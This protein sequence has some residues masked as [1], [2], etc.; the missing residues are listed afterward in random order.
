M[1]NATLATN[2]GLLAGTIFFLDGWGPSEENKSF[3][4]S[5]RFRGLAII[6]SGSIV[7]PVLDYLMKDEKPVFFVNYV[8]GC[9]IGWFFV[10]L[11]G[12]VLYLIWKETKD[13]SKNIIVGIGEFA[14][15]ILD[16]IYLGISNNPHLDAKRKH[17][18]DMYVAQ[19]DSE[20]IR[21]KNKLKGS[22]TTPG[23]VD[24]STRR[25]LEEYQKQLKANKTENDY[26]FSDWYYKG[27]TEFEKGEYEK[28]IAYMKNAMDK[29]AKPEEYA[30]ALLYIGAAYSYL[31]LNQKS[32]EVNNEIISKYPSFDLLDR[33]YYNLG[34]ALTQLALAGVKYNDNLKK[35]L[36]VY[37]Q[38]IQLNPNASLAWSN[39]SYVLY[40][41]GNYKDALTASQKAIDSDAKNPYGW[42][43]KACGEALTD[44][45]T[46]ALADLAKA[47][48]LNPNF[49]IDAVANAAFKSFKDDD[50]FKGLVQ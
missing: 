45:K 12:L 26:D 35:A 36:E 31:G 46:N 5:R 41:L 10:F 47:I 34:V 43:T 21:L 16:F 44:D 40:N 17:D 19:S 3:F 30:N 6:I 27:A 32:I 24:D 14:Y 20:L 39:K 13:S 18:I 4:E 2:I 9:V 42:Y 38:S 23:D 1:D 22:D 25:T 11:L 28:T 15:A 29:P 50:E 33:V 7:T 49:K 37:D 8:K 48:E